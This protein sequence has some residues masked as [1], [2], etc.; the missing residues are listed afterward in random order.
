MSSV[1]PFARAS[2]SAETGRR[3]ASGLTAPREKTSPMR[4]TLFFPAASELRKLTSAPQPI[5]ARLKWFGVRKAF[6]SKFRCRAPSQPVEPMNTPATAPRKPAVHTSRRTSATRR[7]SSA[8]SCGGMVP[9]ISF[10][11]LIAPLWLHLPLC[12]LCTLRGYSCLGYN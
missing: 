9:D 6:G 1:K 3:S 7:A 4:C 12:S 8:V 11:L 5:V 2:C 10:R